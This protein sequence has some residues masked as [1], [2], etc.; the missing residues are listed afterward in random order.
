MSIAE[1]LQEDNLG[2]LILPLLL[3]RSWRTLGSTCR[4]DRDA[5]LPA[6]RKTA[7]LARSLPLLELMR[8]REPWAA[9]LRL[10]LLSGIDADGLSMPMLVSMAYEWAHHG[11]SYGQQRRRRRGEHLA[12]LLAEVP[13]APGEPVVRGIQV[14]MRSE[15]VVVQ[16]VVELG[17][18]LGR[19]LDHVDMLPMVPTDAPGKMQGCLGVTC[20]RKRSDTEATALMWAT[21]YGVRWVE[22]MLRLGADPNCATPQGWTALLYAA[23][24]QS[25]GVMNDGSTDSGEV[26]GGYTTRARGVLGPLLD[27]GAIAR[28]T[29]PLAAFQQAF[30]PTP[31]ADAVIGPVE[32]ARTEAIAG[33]GWADELVGRARHRR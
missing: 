26:Y 32:I 17:L 3:P 11:K 27:A 25:R 8:A 13:A 21:R 28:P 1:R 30:A 31:L 6:H 14:T 33:V 9:A 4:I 5:V 22:L 18:A 16:A 29:L 7:Q 20:T 12:L 10:W 15:L 2:A 19:S 23:A 24:F